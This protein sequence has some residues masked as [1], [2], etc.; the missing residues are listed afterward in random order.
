M[1]RTNISKCSFMTKEV[2][3]DRTEQFREIYKKYDSCPYDVELVA[4]QAGY[5]IIPKRDLDELDAFIGLNMKT[6]FVNAR[7]Y[8]NPSYANRIRFSIAHE[9][10][11][12]ILH[13]EIIKNQHISNIEDYLS[14]E[15]SLSDLEYKGFEW[16]ANEFAG[17]LLVP[18]HHLIEQLHQQIQVLRDNNI[19]HL[20]RSIPDQIRSSMSTPI[21]RFFE[22]SDD[23]IEIRLM[24]EDIWPPDVDFNQEE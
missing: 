6:I 7:T 15:R 18:R 20:L 3:W 16:Q 17:R 23:V 5:E 13:G 22:V 14:F 1:D 4:E 10:G 8:D 11:H 9:L 2:V 12:A 24:R 21:A 19:L